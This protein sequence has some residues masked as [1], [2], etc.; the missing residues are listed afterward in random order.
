[1]PVAP[2]ASLNFYN[3]ICSSSPVL[4]PYPPH[5]HPAPLQH[6]LFTSLLFFDTAYLST[7]QYLDHDWQQLRWHDWIA[8]ANHR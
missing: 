7:I 3:W 1:M 2:P 6:C 5:D 8:E 4:F